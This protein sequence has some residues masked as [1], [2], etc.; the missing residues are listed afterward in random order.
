MLAHILQDY[1]SD[2]DDTLPITLEWTDDQIQI[3]EQGNSDMRGIVVEMS[4]G[5]L[6]IRCYTIDHEEPIIVKL[7]ETSGA[8]VI[9]TLQG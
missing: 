6:Q 2:S 9:N 1:D 3:S 8:E 7:F 4:N 5:T